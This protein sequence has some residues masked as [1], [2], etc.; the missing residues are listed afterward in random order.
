MI[1][2]TNVN[3]N[4]WFILFKKKLMETILGILIFYFIIRKFAKNNSFNDTPGQPDPPINSVNAINNIWF[5]E[6]VIEGFA[7]ILNVKI[8]DSLKIETEKL[9]IYRKTEV[10]SIWKIINESNFEPPF[11]VKNII[12]KLEK[13][14]SYKLYIKNYNLTDDEIVYFKKLLILTIL[15]P[16]F[17]FHAKYLILKTEFIPPFTNYKAPELTRRDLTFEGILP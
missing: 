5:D 1:D 9:G 10:G 8:F 3:T 13:N 17:S 15:H 16:D 12:Y 11:L 14:L 6:S 7:N 4:I 2:T